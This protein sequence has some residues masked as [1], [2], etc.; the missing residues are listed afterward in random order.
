M[1]SVTNDKRIGASI[2]ATLLAA[3]QSP[4]SG[5]SP[6]RIPS[7]STLKL[8]HALDIPAETAHVSFQHGNRVGGVDNTNVSCHFE[9]RDLGPHTVQPDTFTIT[10]AENPQE[11]ISQPTTMQFSKVLYLK[12]AKQP[13]VIDLDCHYWDGPLWGRNITVA[14]VREAVGNYFT[15]ELA[16]SR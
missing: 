3:C 8:N 13:D 12:S 9:V 15:L 14:E 5:P 11:W 4:G 1:I 10:R 2:L 16:P 6:Y 7:G